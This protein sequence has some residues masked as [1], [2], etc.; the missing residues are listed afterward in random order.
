MGGIL[1]G[2]KQIGVIAHNSIK[3]GLERILEPF[4]GIVAGSLNT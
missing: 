1:A 3:N 4:K 2:T